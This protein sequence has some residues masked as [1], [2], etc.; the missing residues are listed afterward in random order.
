MCLQKNK[1]E[2]GAGIAPLVEFPIEKPGAIPTQVLLRYL[3]LYC[4][5]V[6]FH[7]LGLLAILVLFIKEKEKR[8]TQK[9]LTDDN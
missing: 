8:M 2:L 1:K 9:F 3:I 6:K 4:R 5:Q 7:T